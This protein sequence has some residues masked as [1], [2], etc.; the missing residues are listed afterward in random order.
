MTF[1]EAMRMACKRCG[2]DAGHHRQTKTGRLYCLMLNN[3]GKWHR[4]SRIAN[5]RHWRDNEEYFLPVRFLVRGGFPKEV[6]E[7][8]REG[9]TSYVTP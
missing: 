7:V 8:I 1:E 6:G 9:L 5:G 3:N 2:N 4:R